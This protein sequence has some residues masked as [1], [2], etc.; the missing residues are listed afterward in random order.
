MNT[1]KII[2]M[3]LILVTVAAS[4][5]QAQRQARTL[6]DPV[7]SLVIQIGAIS[8]GLIFTSETDSRPFPFKAVRDVNGLT[9]QNFLKSMLR[10]YGS[11][12]V[13]EES[14]ADFLDRPATFGQHDQWVQLK[15]FLE[16]NLVGCTVYRVGT[17]QVDI[18]I[19]GLYGNRPVGVYIQSVET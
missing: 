18:Y 6:T 15:D 8:E 5:V 2:I 13:S 11:E 17:V 7:D 1:A 3:L 19:V 4:A 12:P 10:S 16:A 14:L 9:D